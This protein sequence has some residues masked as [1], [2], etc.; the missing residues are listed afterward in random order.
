MNLVPVLITD[1]TL[2][3]LAELGCVFLVSW[4]AICEHLLL[5]G[6]SN[7]AISLF[8]MSN[9][10]AAVVLARQTTIVTLK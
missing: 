8:M 6:A 4:Q 1:R 7:Q 2:V 9:T 3:K 5:Q 10:G